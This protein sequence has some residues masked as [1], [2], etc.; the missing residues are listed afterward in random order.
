MQKLHGVPPAQLLPRRGIFFHLQHLER[1]PNPRGRVRVRVRVA[2]N[3]SMVT[4]GEADGTLSLRVKTN[5][6]RK[7][8]GS[9]L[10]PGRSRRTEGGYTV[11]DLLEFY[12]TIIR[13]R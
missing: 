11:G 3:V 7:L 4:W 13:H 1:N 2:V 8:L 9:G 12:V 5:L 10:E 6:A